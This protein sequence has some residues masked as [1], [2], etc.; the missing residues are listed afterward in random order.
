MLMMEF[1]ALLISIVLV[2]LLSML[3]RYAVKGGVSLQSSV[4]NSVDVMEPTPV[5]ERTNNVQDT[6]LTH[7]V[8]LEE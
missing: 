1:L 2:N 6:H 4:W 5:S 7:D 3:E 8:L